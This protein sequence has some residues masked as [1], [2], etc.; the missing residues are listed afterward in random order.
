M[1][2][3]LTTNPSIIY[4]V[5]SGSMISQTSSPNA[6]AEYEAW[7]A[8]GNT[9]LPGPFDTVVTLEQAKQ[10][11]IDEINQ[12]CE[13]VI[14][15]GFPSSALGDAHYYDSGIEDQLNLIGAALAAGAG[16]SVE[17]RCYHGSIEGEKEWHVHTPSQMLQVY[18]DGLVYKITQLKKATTLKNIVKAAT[19]L[20]EVGAVEWQ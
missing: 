19:T 14:I 3:Q 5:E 12:A 10:Y 4:M 11:K 20:E 9:P 6:W 7:V 13:Q 1:L 2:Y 17:F 16:Q 15:S 8:A 18:Q